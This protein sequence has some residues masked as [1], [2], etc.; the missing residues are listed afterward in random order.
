[1]ILCTACMVTELAY[2]STNTHTM[3][4]ET[5]LQGFQTRLS[6]RSTFK[7]PSKKLTHRNSRIEE[8]PA[9]EREDEQ[10]VPQTQSLPPSSEFSHLSLS[11]SLSLSTYH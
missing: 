4:A 6:N 7:R 5:L 2:T 3:Q 1:M 11:L 8:K 10:K 9:T